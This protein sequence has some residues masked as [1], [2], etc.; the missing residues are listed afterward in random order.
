MSVTGWTA[1][2][3]RRLCS[4]QALPADEWRLDGRREPGPCRCACHA[5]PNPPAGAGRWKTACMRGASAVPVG[6]QERHGEPLL[7]GGAWSEADAV[8][9]TPAPGLLRVNLKVRAT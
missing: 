8:T 1:R 5:A 9:L 2:D 3:V 6:E 7:R 4:C